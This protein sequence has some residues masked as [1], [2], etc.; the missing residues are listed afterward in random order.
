M[1]KCSSCE[2]WIYYLCTN[3]RDY[4]LALLAYSNRQ[5][6]CKSC[7][8]IP[9]LFWNPEYNSKEN[10]NSN[11][12]ERCKDK[13]SEEKVKLKESSCSKEKETENLKNLTNEN[14]KSNRK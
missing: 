6:T 8:N 5:Y 3:L 2:G 11:V 4:E 9:K 12:R 10:N 13:G 1:I 7:V 14:E